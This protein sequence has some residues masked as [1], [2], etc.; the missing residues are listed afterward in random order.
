LECQCYPNWHAA[1]TDRLA[2]GIG[3]KI[4]FLPSLIGSSPNGDSKMMPRKFF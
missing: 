3:R 1:D 2:A 4:K